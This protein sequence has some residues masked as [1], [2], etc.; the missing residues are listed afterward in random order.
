[1][2]K[3]KM[4]VLCFVAVL[5]IFT[6][7]PITAH[8]EEQEK[9]IVEAVGFFS[10]F[11][12]RATRQVIEE[13]CA[14]FGDPVELTLYDETKAEG[15]D[16]LTSKGLSGHIPMRLYING[17]N[18]FN[19]DGQEIA[20]R[21]FVDYEWTADDLEKAITLALE[22]GVEGIAI[23]IPDEFAV[24]GSDLTG[25]CSNLPIII[26]VVVGVAIIALA[27]YFIFKPKKTQA[28]KPVKKGRV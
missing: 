11:P 2:R 26:S 8:A 3:W 27:G 13:T 22:S 28:K 10:H 16:F 25:S 19:I 18:A 20:F 15:Q 12:M 1:M 21:D 24:S 23:E 7:L 5:M 14:K 4:T 6:L 17:E 9:V